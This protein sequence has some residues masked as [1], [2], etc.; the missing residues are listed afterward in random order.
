ML[1]GNK[2]HARIIKNCK[3]ARCHLMVHYFDNSKKV[4]FLSCSKAK[5]DDYIKKLFILIAISTSSKGTFY[6]QT[7]NVMTSFLIL[8]NDL[9]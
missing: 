9:R 8:A 3:C 2:F 4:Q 6:K 1:N 5:I 7:K